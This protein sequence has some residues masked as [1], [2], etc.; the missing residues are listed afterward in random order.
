[1]I[2][3]VCFPPIFPRC[4]IGFLGFS[5]KPPG[6]SIPTARRLIRDE[7]CSSFGLNR[8]AAMGFCQA[9]S[10]CLSAV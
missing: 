10:R 7:H 9:A 1:M 8:L 6:G 2:G 4:L 3:T 5:Q